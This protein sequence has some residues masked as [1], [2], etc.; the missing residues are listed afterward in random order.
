MAAFAIAAGAIWSASQARFGTDLFDALP[1][2]PTLRHYRV[3]LEQGGAQGPIT[4]G[5]FGEGAHR[6][7]LIA[8]ADRFVVLAQ[9][10]AEGVIDSVFCRP[11]AAMAEELLAGITD[12]IPLHADAQRLHWLAAADDRALDSAVAAVR[13]AIAAP[14]GE[15]DAERLL[16]DPFGL[17][18]PLRDR[19][20]A[21]VTDGSAALI[22][23]VLFSPDSSMAVALLWPTAQGTADPGRLM[24]V[25]DRCMSAAH[26][27]GITVA[28]FGAA[29]MAVANRS[30][31]SADSMR[32]SAVALTLVLVV[33]MTLSD[34]MN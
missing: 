29:P 19:L 31:I 26:S 14:G 21:S 32:T 5:F 27:S 25:I 13:T 24:D 4:V 30:A 16:A 2:D 20:L 15:F 18:Q 12:R 9:E 33:T 1:D 22:D 7:S 28:A 8:A 6:D 11:D 23:G 17:T 3:L 10:D 34:V